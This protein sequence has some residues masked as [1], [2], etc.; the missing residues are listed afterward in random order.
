M[1]Q[2]HSLRLGLAALVFTVLV[3]PL[4]AKTI[5]ATPHTM[6][7]EI[8]VAGASSL[9]AKHILASGLDLLNGD[10]NAVTLLQAV[11]PP[12]FGSL[13]PTAINLAATT[14]DI[15]DAVPIAERATADGFITTADGQLLAAFFEPG[16][17][18]DG[19]LV[20]VAANESSHPGALAATAAPTG[21]V[22]AGRAP[23]P[24]TLVLLALG[25][26]SLVAARNR[27]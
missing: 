6:V 16:I 23:E 19:A 8:T 1:S 13:D 4:T 25:L 22:L 5:A 11:N 9:P 15:F 20:A 26:V 12:R 7:P 17:V 24:G 21:A 18:D 10:G 14:L 2:A 27:T 3:S